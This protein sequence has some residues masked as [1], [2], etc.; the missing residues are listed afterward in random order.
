MNA[1]LIDRIESNSE[2]GAAAL[3]GAS[4]GYAVYTGLAAYEIGQTSIYAAAA[5][6]AAA[7]LTAEVLKRVARAE[8][9]FSVP[10]F[11]LRECDAFDDGD[12]LLLTHELHDELLLTEADRLTPSSKVLELDQVLAEIGPDAR[13]VR[14]FDRNAMPTPGALKSRIDHHLGEGSA[15]AAPSDA[16]QALSDA[17]AELKRSLH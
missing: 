7:L 13:V 1:T 12:E 16:A 4:I 5:A 3:F 9:H 11:G 17:L 10:V 14:L 2:R 15:P 6:V 8:A